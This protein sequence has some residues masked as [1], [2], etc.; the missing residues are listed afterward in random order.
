[1]NKGVDLKIKTRTKNYFKKDEFELINFVEK[2][3][4][5]LIRRNLKVPI[6]L[7]QL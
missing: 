4:R 5:E 7:Y 6:K 3:F 2:Q 1:M